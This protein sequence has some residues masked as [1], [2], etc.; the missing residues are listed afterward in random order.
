MYRR[1]LCGNRENSCSTTAAEG[2]VR[3]GKARSRSR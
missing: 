3:I 1:S 2:V